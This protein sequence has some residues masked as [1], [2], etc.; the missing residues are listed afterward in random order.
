MATLS[1][2]TW[3]SALSN[4]SSFYNFIIIRPVLCMIIC[5]NLN[6]LFMVSSVYHTKG[7]HYVLRWFLYILFS[8]LSDAQLSIAIYTHAIYTIINDTDDY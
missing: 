8:Y 3:F 6:N 7:G 2:E 5:L 4:V 1:V